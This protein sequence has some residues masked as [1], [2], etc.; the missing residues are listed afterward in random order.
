MGYRT[1]IKEQIAL[2]K[3]PYMDKVQLLG[4]NAAIST[5]AE[6]VWSP[7]ATYAQLT[8][9]AAMEVLSSSANDAAAGTGVRTISVGYI[10]S[11]G[12]QVNTGPISLNG[13][14]P[15]AL[16]VSALAIN[17]INILTTGSGLVN[18]GTIDVRTVSGSV[19][20]RRIASS[21]GQVGQ[22]YDFIYHIPKGCSGLI[23]PIHI[24]ASGA[25][26]AVEVYLHAK[27]STGITRSM[28]TVNIGI[29]QTSIAPVDCI[30]DFGSGA[31]IAENTLI[32]LRAIAAAGAGI[33]SATGEL[34]VV[35]NKNN[36]VV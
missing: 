13:T 25:T 1:F 17:K 28:G 19:V 11:A 30:M 35:D 8:T 12:V 22:S 36:G 15:V 16:G 6:T 24:T 34:I 18:A 9:A 33:L 10:T 14:T 20:K 21:A 4:Y 3:M 7:G 2:G 23:G 26:G 27:D 32:E 29:S 5:S 31:L